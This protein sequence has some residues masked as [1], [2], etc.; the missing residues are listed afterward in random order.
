[1]NQKTSYA[2]TKALTFKAPRRC[3]IPTG[4][5]KFVDVPWTA[6]MISYAMSA[7]AWFGNSSHH[8]FA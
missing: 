6:E 1:M 4:D 5:G 7:G 3:S 2:E 8:D